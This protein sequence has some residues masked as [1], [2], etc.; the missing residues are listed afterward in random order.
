MRSRRR[1]S[2]LAIAAGPCAALAAGD[3][4]A[5]EGGLE[6]FP[7]PALLL[8]LLLLFALLI[9]PV[10]ALIFRPIF[11]VLDARDEKISGT[12][13]RAEKIAADS[14]TLL[15]R[16]EESVRGVREE[17]ERERKQAVAE[18]RGE[19]AA[20]TARARAQA[21]AEIQRARGEIGEALV[22][23]RSTLRAA[24]EQLAREAAARVLGRPL[25]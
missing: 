12:R 18:A 9:A 19:N 6:L 24:A 17:A 11:R 23:A 14:E 1:P 5:S 4:L 25:S 2:L 10:N 16:Y 20:E 15:T 3:A 7:D 22:G 21:E 13:R 8:A